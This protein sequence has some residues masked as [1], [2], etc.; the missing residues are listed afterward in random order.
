MK[1][2]R[3]CRRLPTGE[4]VEM[5]GVIASGL[6]LGA[7]VAGATAGGAVASGAIQ[8]KAA[9]NAAQLQT[10]AANKAAEIQAQ[11]QRE[12]LAFQQQ[13]A[14]EDARRFET[15]QRSNYDQ[16]AARQGYQST[17]GS[18]LGLPSRSIPA[19]V[20]SLPGGS[21]Q[22]VPSAGSGGADPKLRAAIDAY[23]AKNPANI[24]GLTAA[25]KQ[26]GFNV[27][28]FKYN[29][30]VLSNNELNLPGVGKYKVIGAENTPGAYWYQPG[31]ND[32]A[33]GA[34]PARAG[35]GYVA[36]LSALLP[37]PLPSSYTTRGPLTPALRLPGGY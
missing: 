11:S 27:D 15:T 32:S 26:Q 17:I 19:Y 36:P 20:S 3:W 30:G 21:P 22:G 16:W 18:M 13:Q 1:P 12:A 23:A 10:E 24:E 34:A 28:R 29:G 7:L 8:S 31:T 33:S 25:L 5:R 9:G 35:G 37:P 2:E 6:A 4:Y 14:A